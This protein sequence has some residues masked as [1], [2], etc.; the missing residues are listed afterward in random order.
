VL[1]STLLT[2][3]TA[4]ALAGCASASTPA[5][6]GAPVSASAETSVITQAEI[7]E[8]DLP[9]AY[10]LVDRLRR[11]WLRRD[12]ATGSAGAV[13]MDNRFLGGAEKLRDIPAVEVGTMTLV[14]RDDAV[15]RW[16]SEVKGNVI[17]ITRK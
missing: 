8:A 10:E 17:F 1:R 16:G 6:A 2:L 5:A 9:T 3:F 7:V 15:R 11:P 4:A 12:A 13:N 14:R